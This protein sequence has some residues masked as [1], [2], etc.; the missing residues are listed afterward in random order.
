M[1]EWIEIWMDQQ[2]TEQSKQFWEKK[3]GGSNATILQTKQNN[4]NIRIRV[5]MRIKI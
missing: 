2:N 5:K 3:N 1:N 4:L